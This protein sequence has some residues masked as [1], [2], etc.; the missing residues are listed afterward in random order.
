[1]FARLTIR[2]TAKDPSG[3]FDAEQRIREFATKYG[4]KRTETYCF[5]EF[6]LGVADSEM[7]EAIKAYE[8]WS[9]I[10]YDNYDWPTQTVEMVIR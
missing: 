7:V 3:R 8:A 5:R 2:A 4:W 10:D 6:E 1:M 9:W